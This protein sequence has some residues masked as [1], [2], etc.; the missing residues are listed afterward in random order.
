MIS[1][2]VSQRT[3]RQCRGPPGAHWMRSGTQKNVVDV[4]AAQPSKAH[5]CTSDT[6]PCGSVLC[7]LIIGGEVRD[8]EFHLLIVV[9]MDNEIGWKFIT[10]M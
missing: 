9:K 10:W 7:L 6:V 3:L 2:E 8:W 4:I 5:Q 1:P